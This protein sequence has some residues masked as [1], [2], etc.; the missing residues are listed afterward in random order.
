MSS[1]TTLERRDDGP[2]QVVVDLDP[3]VVLREIVSRVCRAAA[4]E[5]GS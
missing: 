3:P 1:T 4:I 2:H 5:A